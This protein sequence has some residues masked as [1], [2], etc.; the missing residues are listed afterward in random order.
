MND[1]NHCKDTIHSCKHH[2]WVLDYQSHTYILIHAY[3]KDN[4]NLAW[5]SLIVW[6]QAP[7]SADGTERESE[8]EKMEGGR[9][10]EAT[11]EVCE[12]SLSLP[13]LKLPII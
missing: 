8:R 13:T 6:C 12:T 7:H 10:G 1:L 5:R 3:N 4:I 9:E 2:I 11:K